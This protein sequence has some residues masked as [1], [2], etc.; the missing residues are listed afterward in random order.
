MI[1][2]GLYSLPGNVADI[3]GSGN[4][5]ALHRETK[6]Q[7]TRL[8]NRTRLA[9]WRW[10][11]SLPATHGFNRGARLKGESDEQPTDRGRTCCIDAV[12]T[13]RLQNPDPD[14]D[15]GQRRILSRSAERTAARGRTA[16]AGDGR[17]SRRQTGS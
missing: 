17:R 13:V 14:P 5:A 6:E 1:S 3:A 15:R 16:A 10:R 11:S 2:S 9:E 7:S 8:G 12:G 4:P